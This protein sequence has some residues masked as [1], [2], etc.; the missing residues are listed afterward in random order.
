DGKPRDCSPTI[1]GREARVMRRMVRAHGR[2]ALGIIAAILSSAVGGINT[3]ATRF[4]IGATDPVTLAALRFGLGFLLL[5]PIALALCS[6]WPRRQDWIGAALLGILF[7]AVYFG[8][9][10]LALR[11]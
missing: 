4:A 6:R 7:F 11:Y 3:A 9:F 1:D 8:L 2:E 10:N 5:L